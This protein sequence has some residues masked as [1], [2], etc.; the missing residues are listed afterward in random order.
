MFK[1]YYKL[2]VALSKLRLTDVERGIYA[3]I[4]AYG[5]YIPCTNSYQGSVQLFRFDSGS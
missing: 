2:M 1:G 5:E 4:C 3:R